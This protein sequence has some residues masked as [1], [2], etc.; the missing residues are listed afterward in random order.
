MVGVAAASELLVR[1]FFLAIFS[2]YKAPSPM[3]S[4]RKMKRHDTLVKQRR[5]HPDVR[6]VRSDR[7]GEPARLLPDGLLHGLAPASAS[8][9]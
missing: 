1:S 3:G 4:Y 8:T 6:F 9:G 7:V 5:P 2:L